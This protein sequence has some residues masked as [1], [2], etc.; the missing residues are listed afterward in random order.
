MP[1][2]PRIV[3]APVEYIP[4]LSARF[5][6]R[7]AVC[8]LVTVLDVAVVTSFGPTLYQVSIGHPFWLAGLTT[9]FAAMFFT[10]VHAWL[11][12]LRGRFR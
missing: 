3:S 7:L 10:L 8:V 2:I 6:R 11:Q 1:N 9:L 4:V 12:T 5:A